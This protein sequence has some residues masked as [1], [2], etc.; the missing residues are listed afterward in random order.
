M[1]LRMLLGDLRSWLAAES[2][3][4]GA[5]DVSVLRV[6][7]GLSRRQVF[8]RGLGMALVATGLDKVPGVRLF[9]SL[10]NNLQPNGSGAEPDGTCRSCSGPCDCGSCN[11]ACYSP[12]M[13]YWVPPNSYCCPGCGQ[14]LRI[15]VCNN[16]SASYSCSDC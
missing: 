6:A 10:P 9:E 15:K 5:V 8:S 3:G 1:R 11:P 12:N 4:L 16:G 13:E 7:T 14:Y 2:N